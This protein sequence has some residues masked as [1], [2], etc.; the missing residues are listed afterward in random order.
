ML[1]EL[2][3]FPELN[4]REASFER[5]RD[6]YTGRLIRNRVR[7]V[8]WDRDTHT[9]AKSIADI[10]EGTPLQIKRYVEAEWPTDYYVTKGGALLPS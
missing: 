9:G 2:P 3:L 10:V 6:D 8:L 7:A 5:V 1:E 4:G